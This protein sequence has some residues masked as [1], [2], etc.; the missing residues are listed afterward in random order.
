MGHKVLTLY[1]AIQA[2]AGCQVSHVFTHCGTLG[3]GVPV[4]A[5]T[6]TRE[7]LRQVIST[8]D[9]FTLLGRHRCG[10]ERPHRAALTLE[11]LWNKI[12]D[13]TF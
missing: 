12:S 6:S 10:S 9:F 4:V 1:Q 7:R 8:N 2:D 5:Q 3:N 13:G 11:S